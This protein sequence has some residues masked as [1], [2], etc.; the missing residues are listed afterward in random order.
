MLNLLAT[1]VFLGIHVTLYGLGGIG[2]A[3][4][5]FYHT[6]PQSIHLLP[7]RAKVDTVVISGLAIEQDDG[8]YKPTGDELLQ[9]FDPEEATVLLEAI[10][11]AGASAELTPVNES[12][13]IVPLG[14]TPMIVTQLYTLLT[15]QGS[16]IRK[17]VLVYPANSQE[18]KNGADLLEKAFEDEGKGVRCLRE[19]VPGYADID[20]KQACLAYER[21]LEDAIDAV[22]KD[23]QVEL[24]LSGGRK[25]M[26]A[27]AMFVAQRKSIRYIYHTLI[28]DK[29]LSD[30]VERETTI[31]ALRGTQASKQ[32]RNDRLFLREYEGNGPYTTFVL[33]RVP[34]LPAKG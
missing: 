11:P 27:L 22:R 26:A 28:N 18:I 17:V 2:Y 25:G 12:M 21:T 6:E 5:T 13:L 9:A 29:Q 16:N 19:R 8:S 7:K 24:A 3:F 4:D 20:S 31:S 10:L 1:P 15:Y 34:V 14:T 32:V 33:F 30:K 23:Y